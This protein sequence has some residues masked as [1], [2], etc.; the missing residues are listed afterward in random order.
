MSGDHNMRG[1]EPFDNLPSYSECNQQQGR[2]PLPY[3]AIEYQVHNNGGFDVDIRLDPENRK[4]EAVF[5]V[6]SQ[7]GDGITVTID[8]LHGLLMAADKLLKDKK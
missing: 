6:L 1:E 4:D 5:F 3:K 7:E 2:V 8:C